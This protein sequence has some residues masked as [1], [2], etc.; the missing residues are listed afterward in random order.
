[1]GNG[2][3]EPRPV[4]DTLTSRNQNIEPIKDGPIVSDNEFKTVNPLD[5][6][7]WD[8]RVLSSGSHCVFHTRAWAQTLSQSY[9]FEPMYLTRMRGSQFDVLVPL[10]HVHSWVTGRRGVSLPF[11]DYCE[12]LA[13]S[14]E[15]EKI[16]LRLRETGVLHRWQY[17]EV[18]HDL[19]WPEV[20]PASEILWRHE[21]DLK[22][23][24]LALWEGLRSEVRTAI[25]KAQAC[26][27]EV[28]F[29]RTLEDLHEFFRIHLL[30]RRKQGIPPQP[31]NFFEKVY[32]N[33]L[34]PGLGEIGIAHR[35][36]VNLATA[37]YFN[38]GSSALFKYGASDP[39]VHDFRGNNA[40]MW[41]AIL[42]YAQKGYKT[43][44][45]GRTDAAHHGL[46]HYKLGW[47]CRESPLDY[48]RYDYRLKKFTTKP[49]TH[50]GWVRVLLRQAPLPLLK[51]AGTW[52]YPHR[53]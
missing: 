10:M 5:D 23:T 15:I 38:F 30:T 52:L 7:N 51:M 17:L 34:M 2:K 19:H 50:T 11:S 28:R 4:P 32:H 43:L 45:M 41:A 22:K 24:P 3:K 47:G 1:M 12:W 39:H 42:R 44:S 27:V 13:P 8:D 49:V 9:G 16:F 36:G 33:I 21:L 48:F 31:W 53:S 14:N 35:K 6:P 25:R 37:V 26:G 29:T 46:R 40:L 18:R 20:T